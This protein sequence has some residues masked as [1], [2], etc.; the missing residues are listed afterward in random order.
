MDLEATKLQLEDETE[1]KA[2]LQKLL[3]KV[4]DETRHLRER[5]EKDIEAKN[6]A[7]EDQRFA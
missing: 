2:E 6:A 1:A 4:Q 3:L 5:F 7:I